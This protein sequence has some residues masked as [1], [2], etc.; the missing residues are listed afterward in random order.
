MKNTFGKLRGKNRKPNCM[1]KMKDKKNNNNPCFRVIK[2][3][4]CHLFQP[5]CG[6]FLCIIITVVKRKAPI[7]K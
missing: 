5:S 7:E 3:S 2:N 6:T 1:H 4:Y